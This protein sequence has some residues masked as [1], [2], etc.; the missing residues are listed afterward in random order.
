MTRKCDCC[1]FE[2]LAKRPSSRFCGARCRIS[3]NRRKV[4]ASVCDIL[5]IGSLPPV[6]LAAFD[7]KM[8]LRTIAADE[9]QPAAAR[10]AACRILITATDQQPSRAEKSMSLLDKRTLEVLNRRVH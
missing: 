8:T 4:P 9:R 10:V 7:P 5:G 2:Y 3:A 6:D 1:G